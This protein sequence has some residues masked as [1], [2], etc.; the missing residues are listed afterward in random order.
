LVLLLEARCCIFVYAHEQLINE[1]RRITIMDYA[2]T[3][4]SEDGAP[5]AREPAVAYGV[6]AGTEAD[7]LAASILGRPESVDEDIYD[8][9][10]DLYKDA[11]KDVPDGPYSGDWLDWRMKNVPGFKEAFLSWLEE[12]EDEEVDEDQLLTTDEVFAEIEWCIKHNQWDDVKERLM[13]NGR[14]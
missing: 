1:Y 11:G 3:P 4:Q 5:E 8:D 10:G 14:I 13:K 12:G 9:L 7:R 2:S 6:G